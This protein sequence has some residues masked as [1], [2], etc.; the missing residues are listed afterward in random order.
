MKLAPG[1]SS[2]IA[3]R[4]VCAPSRNVSERPRACSSR[5]V[6]TCPRSGSPAS[7][8]S[9]M[10]RKSTS[11]LR[12]MASTV[13]HPIARPLRLDLFLARDQRDLVGADA[14]RDLVVD[15][16]RQ[17]PQRQVRSCR[18]RARAC[19]RWRG[20]SCRC[21]WA[22]ELLSRCGCAIRSRWPSR[23]TPYFHCP[24]Q[25]HPQAREIKSFL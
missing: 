25:M 7:W 10:A 19:A 2:E 1:I 15:L 22:R 14:R 16:A 20:A 21:S 6:K 11:T 23:R 13:A 5:S 9:S 18:C 24:R 4:M 12:G 3:S 17:E 8:I